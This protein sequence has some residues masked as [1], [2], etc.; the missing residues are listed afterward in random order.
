MPPHLSVCSVIIQVRLLCK[1][2]G[3]H[4]EMKLKKKGGIEIPSPGIQYRIEIR[5]INAP[6]FLSIITAV[7]ERRNV[8]VD[9]IAFACFS[10]DSSFET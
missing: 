7:N 5:K 10:Y 6:L 8:N 9:S 2:N 4:S 1:C 3:K